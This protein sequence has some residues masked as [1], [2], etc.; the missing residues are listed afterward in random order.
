MPLLFYCF[1]FSL[2]E[3]HHWKTFK[4]HFVGSFFCCLLWVL[5]SVA[6][7]FEFL[8]ITGRVDRLVIQHLN[9]QG[10]SIPRRGLHCF[11]R[12]NKTWTPRLGCIWHTNNHW[13]QIKSEK[14]AG[15]QSKGVN[16]SKK[17]PTEHYKD[18]FSNIQKVVA[19]LLLELKDD[20]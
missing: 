5:H 12:P 4:N 7:L 9:A 13:K 16:N 17:Q 1:F 15:P 3:Y 8:I 6:W 11:W 14:V 20:L 10:R 19:L 18:C 2:C